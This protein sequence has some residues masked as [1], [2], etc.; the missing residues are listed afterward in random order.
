MT[1]VNGRTRH[2]GLLIPG[3]LTLVPFFFENLA[4]DRLSL[5][6]FALLLCGCGANHCNVRGATSPP[7]LNILTYN[8]HLVD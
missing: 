7:V 3:D 4:V 2:C 6:V 1:V 8:S 5:T